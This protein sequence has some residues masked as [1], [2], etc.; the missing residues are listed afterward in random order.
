MLTDGRLIRALKGEGVDLVANED[1]AGAMPRSRKFA[2]PIYL[3]DGRTIA[4]LGEAREMML[5]G[6]PPHQSYALWRGAIDVLKAAAE[7][8]VPLGEALELFKLALEAEG[9]I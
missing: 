7:E 4:T 9:L 5:F 6:R 8:R 2:K 3:K 1:D